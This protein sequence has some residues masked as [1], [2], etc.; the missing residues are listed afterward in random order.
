[1]TESDIPVSVGEAGPSWPRAKD[2]DS[3]SATAAI[4]PAWEAR[5][6]GIAEQSATT[7]LELAES[8]DE[9]GPSWSKQRAVPPL[10][11]P[12]SLLVKLG[13]QGLRSVA[14]HQNPSPNSPSVKKGN[15]GLP[16]NGQFFFLVDP[17]QY[18]PVRP[19][20][21]PSP[22]REIQHRFG[23]TVPIVESFAKIHDFQ[24]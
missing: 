3:A 21:D 23:E 17:G 20:V 24:V 5:P 22:Y 1:M 2:V 14:S 18:R 6:P 11:Q 15:S 16:S 9:A 4:K 8:S 10:Q 13:P 7:E 19:T 12:S